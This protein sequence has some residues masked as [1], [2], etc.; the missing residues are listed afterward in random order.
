MKEG[1]TAA[2]SRVCGWRAPNV[3]G[4]VAVVMGGGERAA[5]RDGGAAKLGRMPRE[6]EVPRF[7][8]APAR[9]LAGKLQ[10]GLGTGFL[11]ALKTPRDVVHPLLMDCIR[12]DPRLDRQLD[13]RET[14]YAELAMQVELP[15]APVLEELIDAGAD[16][17]ED[18]YLTVSV[19]IEIARRGGHQADRLLRDYVL[20][21][22]HWHSVCWRLAEAAIT[23]DWL[24]LA[25]ELAGRSELDREQ[26]RWS[27]E[28]FVTWAKYEPRFAVLARKEPRLHRK[29]HSGA[30]GVP[31]KGSTTALLQHSGGGV[32]RAIAELSRR[33]SRADLDLIDEATSSPSAMTRAIAISAQFESGNWA[34]WDLAIDMA[35]RDQHPPYATSIANRAILKAPAG[36]LIP[37][38]AR[39]RS[40]SNF[41]RRHLA[42]EIL[43][44]HAAPNDRPWLERKLKRVSAIDPSDRF[45]VTTIAEIVAAR[46]PG[47][48]F[49]GLAR[50][51]DAFTYSFGR[52]F[53]A[54][55]LAATDPTFA[56]TRAFTGLWDCESGVREVAAKHV[57]LD[58]PGARERLGEMADDE[59][60]EDGRVAAAARARLN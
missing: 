32:T 40:S 37:L 55:A 60:D 46:F 29:E 24:E 16:E 5:L 23:P 11:E 27:H 58:V 47:S 7:S 30:P 21:G 10:R 12:V 51:F 20:W 48:E 9:T 50:K 14:Y 56:T 45:L 52:H 4:R 18:T 2:M 6:R 31:L 28:P 33:R 13:N 49:P 39:W 3:E 43:E 17:D 8:Y 26:G 22:P 59:L 34:H 57:S 38:A 41:R 1:S 44:Q 35:L 53:I 25:P 19:L 42:W 15:L 36:V 54:E